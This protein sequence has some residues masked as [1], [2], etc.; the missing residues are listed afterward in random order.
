MMTE[1]VVSSAYG[2]YVFECPAETGGTYYEVRKGMSTIKRC[3]NLD[4][5][6]R[7]I[8]TAYERDENNY[9]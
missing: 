9:G 2:Y 1:Q 4:E 7:F 3:S 5:A 8:K 6:E